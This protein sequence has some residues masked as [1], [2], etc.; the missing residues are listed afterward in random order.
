MKRIDEFPINLAMVDNRSN[1]C[2]ECKR[3]RT[4]ELYDKKKAEKYF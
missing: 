2:K 4:K 3:K 1:Y